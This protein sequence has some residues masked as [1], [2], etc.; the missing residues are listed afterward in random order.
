MNICA[1]TS[2]EC[3]P[4]HNT[5]S[6]LQSCSEINAIL[7]THVPCHILRIRRQKGAVHTEAISPK[8]MMPMLSLRRQ[9]RC[10]INGKLA[11]IV[12]T[13]YSFVQFYLVLTTTDVMSRV[14]SFLG[15]CAFLLSFCYSGHTDFTHVQNGPCNSEPSLHY[16]L[17]IFLCYL[18]I[19]RRPL[20]IQNSLS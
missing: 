19:I 7:Q 5:N 4:R 12:N 13:I 18:R 3:G 20:V 17:E 14:Y 9:C 15:V 16:A 8:P 10:Y 11:K 2:L 6:L 1:L